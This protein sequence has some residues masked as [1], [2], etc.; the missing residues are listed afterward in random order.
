MSKS[1]VSLMLLLMCLSTKGQE[2]LI[3]DST[4]VDEIKKHT[5]KIYNN[6]DKTFF[7][8]TKKNLRQVKTYG[9][10]IIAHTKN[11][12]INRIISISMTKSG[13]LS[14]EWYFWK[15]K[16]IYAYESF[17]FFSEQKKKSN[18]KNFKDLH[19]WESR[20]YFINETIKYQ[21]HK[22]KKDIFKNDDANTILKDGYAIK[23]Y[24][25]NK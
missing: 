6:K 9:N 22:D 7:Y 11:D 17:E 12:S 21:K 14:T 8:L 4:V 19:A 23:K 3:G 24:I 18:W 10:N 25:F 20:Y 15:N 13:Q 1:I 5:S 16:L 2:L